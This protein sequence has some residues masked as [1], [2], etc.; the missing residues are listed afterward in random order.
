[1]KEK[2]N[3]TSGAPWW[4][5]MLTRREANSLIV[6][7]GLTAALLSSAGIV[8]GCGGDDDDDEDVDR[9]ALE[10]QQKEGWN[11]GSTNHTLVLPNTASSDSKGSINWSTYLDPQALLKAYQPHNSA[12][13][14]FVVTTLVQSL[15]QA[16]LRSQMKPVYSRSME[17][18]YSRG[19]GM[20]EI[21][22]KSKNAGSTMLV[23]DLPGPESIAYG[24][25]LADVADPVITFDNW[26]HPLGVVHS[27]ETLGAMLYYAAEISEKSA[28]R[29]A[30]APAVFL[31]D[32]NRLNNFSNPDTQFDNRY[33]AKLPTAD[34]LVE[35]KITNI[36]YAV[37]DKSRTT[38]LD[39][40]N[41][42]F[43]LFKEK[44]ISVS[45]VTLSDFQPDPNATAST[46]GGSTYVHNTYY[47]GGGMMYSPWFY[48]H[49]PVFV[50]MYSIPSRAH[51]P[52]TSLS[53]SSYSPVRRPTVFSSRSV[54]G[55]SGI[56]KQRP[57]GFGRVSTRVGS[58][59]RTT[60]IRAGRSGSFGRA[61]GGSS[62]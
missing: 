39:D 1:M 14:P 60:G 11:V 55:R 61:R 24:A 35:K 2:K 32:S 50:P 23:V 52:S 43:A 21:L 31:L 16:S 44:G 49:Y 17:E 3:E 33:L 27:Q 40:I 19:L 26:P 8:Q 47:Y 46:A 51:L 53:G 4:K 13:Q 38:E 62:S 5:E 48:Y 56:G 12:W 7:F 36:M 42:D 9:D 45:M 22:S 54:G 34:K 37:P 29:A 41:E 57:T 58:D 28:K 6:K 10:L 18:A 20:R 30:D 25:A 15:G 59:G